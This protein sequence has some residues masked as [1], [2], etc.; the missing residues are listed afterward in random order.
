M[1]IGSVVANASLKNDF[2]KT[3]P[4]R[5]MNRF[6]KKTSCHDHT[7]KFLCR[8]DLS[9]IPSPWRRNTPSTSVQGQAGVVDLLPDNSCMAA[10]SS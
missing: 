1:I 3:T 5:S 6:G 9:R 7:F 4:W 10:T 2:N 8:T